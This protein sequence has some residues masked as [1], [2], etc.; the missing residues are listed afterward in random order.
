MQQ[1][2]NVGE[3]PAEW[4]VQQWLNLPSAKQ[5]VQLADYQ[6]KILYL[7]CFQAWC[8]GCHSHGFPTLLETQNHFKDSDDVEFVAIQTV[9]EGFEQN[10]LDAAGQVIKRH[11][12]SMPVGHDPGPDGRRS[13][14]LENYHTG[15]TPWAIIIGKDGIVRYSDF[16]LS[17]SEAVGLINQ[18]Q[19]MKMK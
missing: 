2:G 12:L 5:T 13:W 17:T 3:K 11:G 1:Y 7:Y 14:I 16:R 9:F 19:T 15:G 10:T 4:N 18:L 8:P 6:G